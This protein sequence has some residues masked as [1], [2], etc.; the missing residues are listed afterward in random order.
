MDGPDQVKKFKEMQK[1]ANVPEDFVIL[2]DR[3]YSA[4]E[5]W[6]KTDQ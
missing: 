3:W 6:F 2:R 4:S 5:V 1:T